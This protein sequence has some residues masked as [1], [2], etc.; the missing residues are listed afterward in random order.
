MVLHLVEKLLDHR[1]SCARSNYLSKLSYPSES[2]L[3]VLAEELIYSIRARS[4]LPLRD[5]VDLAPVPR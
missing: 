5:D 1:V 3:Q 2:A 4:S